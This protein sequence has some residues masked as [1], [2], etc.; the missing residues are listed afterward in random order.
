MDLRHRSSSA[1]R[2]VVRVI[3]P[4]RVAAACPQHVPAT[5]AIPFGWQIATERPM[6]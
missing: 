6:E 1:Y 4:A 5:P 3:G 2:T